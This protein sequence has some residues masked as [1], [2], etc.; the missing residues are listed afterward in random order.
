[1]KITKREREELYQW[2]RT[3]EAALCINCKH[4]YQ[5]YI[6]EHEEN[7]IGYCRP[8]DV[9]HCVCPRLKIRR[10]YDTC[11]RFENKNSPARR[12]TA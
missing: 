1:M 12:T 8:I 4:F 11:E 7:H 10:A 2:N 5:H 3:K 9:G 6:L